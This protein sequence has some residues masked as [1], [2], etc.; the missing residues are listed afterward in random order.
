M[1]LNLDLVVNEIWI[2]SF[3]TRWNHHLF[4]YGHVSDQPYINYISHKNFYVNDVR[5]PQIDVYTLLFSFLVLG[6]NLNIFH[7]ENVDLF[8]DVYLGPHSSIDNFLVLFFSEDFC[9]FY[10]PFLKIIIFII[11]IF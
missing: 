8:L 1:I 2:S 3:W 4:L 5:S 10:C 11:F 7:C 6:D 9:L